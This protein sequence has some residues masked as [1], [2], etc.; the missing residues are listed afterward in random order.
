MLS[1]K[2]LTCS[3]HQ[4]ELCSAEINFTSAIIVTCHVKGCLSHLQKRR[5]AQY[6]SRSH[7]QPRAQ[8]CPVRRALS[9]GSGPEF[10]QLLQRFQPRHLKSQKFR[11]VNGKWKRNGKGMTRRLRVERYCNLTFRAIVIYRKTKLEEGK[12]EECRQN[13]GFFIYPVKII[14]KIIINWQRMAERAVNM[15]N[16]IIKKEKKMRRKGQQVIHRTKQSDSNSDL[17]RQAQQSL[18]H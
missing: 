10:A 5:L 2:G 8:Q 4:G 16:S 11:I 12:T 3:S 13:I 1:D 9:P 15:H 14:H 18:R 7:L 17:T 6:H